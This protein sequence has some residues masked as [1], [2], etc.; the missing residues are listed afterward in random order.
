M[1]FKLTEEQEQIVE[2]ARWL[3]EEKLAPRAQHYDKTGTHPKESWNDIWESGFLGIAIPKEF[4]GLG[5]DMLTYALVIETL[6]QGC[7]STG[8]TVH[9]HSVVQRF[10]SELGTQEQK[11]KF[12]AEVI[13]DGRVFGSW[14][15]EP[16][17]R[18][19]TGVGDTVVSKREGGYYLNGRKHFCTMAGATRRS[20]VHS[21]MEGM[22][23]VSGYILAIP[24]EDAPGQTIVGEWDVL[25]MRATVSPG[26]AFENCEL[27][28]DE[29]L[30][31][32]GRGDKLGI[33][34]SFG[35]GYASV[36]LG[37]AQRALDFVKDYSKTHRFDP[38][39]V[40]LSH[41]LVV[42]RRVT[43][44]TMAL[45]GA[46]LSIYK[47]ASLW[48]DANPFE[49]AVLSAKAK[50]MATEAA[51]M[52]TEKAIQTVGGRSAHVSI[53]LG[54][55]F[56][57]VRTCTLMPPNSDRQMEIIGRAEMQVDSEGD[58]MLSR[59]THFVS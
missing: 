56:R 19:G 42:Q 22:D 53:P 30:G 13:D 12:Y 50:Y 25:G 45:E 40:P 31:Q 11:E 48:A 7:T 34:Q 8:M 15:S 46:R 35:L 39:P 36:Y 14:G 2:K 52:V 32:P 1:D 57:D 18:G 54:R 58:D 59:L 49:R 23:S 5:L 17:R 4:G 47:A 3:A 33:G 41:S 24:S 43:E 38:E 10:I 27:A 51:L 29:I 26:V 9:M 21:T 20:I 44:M 37:A 16:N 55:I 28:E 6:T